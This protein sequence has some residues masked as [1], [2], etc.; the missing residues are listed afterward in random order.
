VVQYPS[1]A[2]VAARAQLRADWRIVACEHSFVT[3]N[4]EDADAYAPAFRKIYAA[5]LKP[6]YN[7]AVDRVLM[8]AQEGRDDLVSNFGVRA[9]RIVVVPNPIDLPRVRANGEEP[10]EDP[11][12]PYEPSRDAEVPV[13]VGAGR[14]VAQKRFDHLVRAFAVARKVRSARLILSGSG[15]GRADLETLARSLG[16]AADVRFVETSPPWR[17]MR[18]AA[19]FALSSEWEGFPMVLAEA[20]ALGCPIVSYACPSGPREMLDGGRGGV[21]VPS[22]D[23]EALGAAMAEALD[24]P[25]RMRALGEHASRRAEAYSI[26]QVVARYEELFTELARVRP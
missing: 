9:H 24:D 4:L 11:W 19:L 21:L 3:K 10:L 6:T 18:R 12:L 17:H 22:G 23:V 26:P 5:A 20:M 7:H 15:Q 8:T 16:I 25:S 2:L 1:L 13:I 14:F